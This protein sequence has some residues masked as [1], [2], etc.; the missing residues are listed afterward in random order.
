MR[1]ELRRRARV[2]NWATRLLLAPALCAAPAMA[3]PVPE[4]AMKAAFIF[5]FAVFA[6]W[7]LDALAAGAPLR[8]CAS[9]GS[10]IYSAIEPLNDKP[11]NGH[12][13]LLRQLPATPLRTCHMLVLAAQDRDNWPQWRREL[14]G[15]S[16]LTVS[17]DRG[18]RAEGAVIGLSADYERIG[19]DVNIGAARAARLNISSKLLR[20]ARSVR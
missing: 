6:E 16:V 15:A 2:R 4:Y 8:V 14:S 1:S 5:N 18:I 19:F 7:P 10:A 9:P 17:D 13:I 3:D 12:R 20:L 11:V